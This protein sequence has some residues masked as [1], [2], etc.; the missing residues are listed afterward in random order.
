MPMNVTAADDKLGKIFFDYLVNQDLM[1]H[2]NHLLADMVKMHQQ[3]HLCLD[4]IVIFNF[5]SH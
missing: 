4:T 3:S 1:F 5:A 2:V